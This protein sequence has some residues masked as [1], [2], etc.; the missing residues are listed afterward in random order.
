MGA[1]WNHA[2]VE[3]TTYKAM[4]MYRNYD[5]NSLHVRRDEHRRH[6]TE[7]RHRLAFARSD[8]L[9]AL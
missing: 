3:H 6:D 4:K 8:R 9:T 7:S 5:G 2:R 1:R